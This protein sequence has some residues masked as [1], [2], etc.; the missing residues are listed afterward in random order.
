MNVTFPLQL[1]KGSKAL[2]FEVGVRRSLPLRSGIFVFF[3]PRPSNHSS[4]KKAFLSQ[5]S[6]Y[7]D[8][9]YGKNGSIVET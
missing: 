8:A 1:G 4:I 7:F 6:P 9:P 5:Q 3:R 2:R